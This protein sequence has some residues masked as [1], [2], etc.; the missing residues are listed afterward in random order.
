MDFPYSESSR[1]FELVEFLQ[2][3]NSK[4]IS[5]MLL[6]VMCENELPCAHFP[7]YV[8]QLKAKRVLVV[9]LGTPEFNF[10]TVLTARS[11][12]LSCRTISNRASESDLAPSNILV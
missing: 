9:R 1:P 6:P 7:D 4:L 12:L 8:V 2:I 10:S 5:I 3:E 11:A